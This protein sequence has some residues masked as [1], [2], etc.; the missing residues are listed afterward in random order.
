MR[1]SIQRACKIQGRRLNRQRGAVLFIALVA[2]VTIMLAAVTLMRSVDTATIIAGNLAYKQ[3]ATS[4]G[5]GGLESAKTW[6]TQTNTANLAKDP[7]LDATHA[8]NLTSAANGYYS[9]VNLDSNF[10]TASTTWVDGASVNVGTDVSGNTVRYIIQRMCRTANQVLSVTDCLFSDAK[11]EGGSQTVKSG[12]EAGLKE[13]GKV[14]LN[15]IT[16]RVTGPRN[17]ISYIQAF[18]Y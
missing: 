3:A 10:V 15:R 4:S 7:F 8:F 17:T 16:I 18:I 2:M 9:Y 1:N 14:P 13:S 5:D 12:D 6:L 11:G